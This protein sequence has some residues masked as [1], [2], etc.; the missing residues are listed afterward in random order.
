[1]PVRHVLTRTCHTCVRISFGL[2][3]L[4]SLM[5]HAICAFVLLPLLLRS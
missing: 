1:M 2:T 5:F 3:E 4:R